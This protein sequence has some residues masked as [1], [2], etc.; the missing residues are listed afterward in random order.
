MFIDFSYLF[1]EH[2]SL[3]RIEKQTDIYRYSNL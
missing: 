3:Q 1:S 2:S